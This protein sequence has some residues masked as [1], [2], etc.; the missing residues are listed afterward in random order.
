MHQA[1]RFVKKELNGASY[2][3]NESAWYRIEEATL[4][5]NN[6]WSIVLNEDVSFDPEIYF[7][8][9]GGNRDYLFVKEES[10]SDRFFVY[11]QETNDNVSGYLAAFA[12]SYDEENTSPENEAS[13]MA[14]DPFAL[15][16]GHDYINP[17]G[18]SISEFE[19]AE[20]NLG[21]GVD[22][23]D[24]SK[25]LYRNDGFQ[26]FTVVNLVKEMT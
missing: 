23:F 18:V 14:E 13:K 22:I 16:F 10:C 19:Y 3:E 26:T 9:L 2:K 5:D 8:L 15:R 12:D 25:A 24:V 7:A 17:L 21:A 1:I 6:N 11:N 4:L 20:I